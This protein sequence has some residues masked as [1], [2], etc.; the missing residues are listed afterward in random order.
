M[1]DSE[2]R[3]TLLVFLC[4]DNTLNLQVTASPSPY[5][6]FLAI[7]KYGKGYHHY[8]LGYMRIIKL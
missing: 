1:R 4:Y 5:F 8:N 2:V 6:D 7:Q 3:P